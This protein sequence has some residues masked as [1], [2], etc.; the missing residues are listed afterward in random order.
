MSVTETEA[1]GPDLPEIAPDV[2]LFEMAG[3]AE[4]LSVGCRWCDAAFGI[5]KGSIL[6]R[7][8]HEKKEHPDEWTAN[9]IP[10]HRPKSER[11]PTAPAKGPS[12]KPPPGT[13]RTSAT[14]Q[15]RG[16]PRPARRKSG[17]DLLAMAVGGLSWVM[18]RQAGPDTPFL[19]PMARMVG[20]EAPIAGT[21]LDAAVAGTIVDRM[22]LQPALDA[23]SR[24]EA[25]GPLIAAPLL[26]GFAASKPSAW[27][28]VEPMLRRCLIPM[29]PA[30]VAEMRRQAAETDMLKA[31]AAQLADMDPAFAE[32]FAS[33]G[34]PLD[35]IIAL[36][37]P[38][39]PEG[40]PDEQPDSS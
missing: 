13:P 40:R 12:S 27:P 32:I 38:P 31:Q 15:D 21:Q 39:P 4:G 6:A 9:R 35:A 10:R 16:A 28:E 18:A 29:L 37:F 11:R 1:A 30:M 5:G 23:E 3:L 17:A 24:L 19:E 20:F 34:D 25:I 36:I 8:R 33:G 7:G 22:F 14:R 2:S 26:V